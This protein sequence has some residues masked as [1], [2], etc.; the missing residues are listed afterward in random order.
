MHEEKIK[1]AKDKLDNELLKK[2]E[3]LI[4]FLNL[5]L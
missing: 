2:K 1:K 3:V 4:F 5:Y